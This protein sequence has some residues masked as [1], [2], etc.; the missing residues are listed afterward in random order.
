MT[1]K[2]F[3]KYYAK[4]VARYFKENAS[5]RMFTALAM[6]LVFFLVAWGVYAFAYRGFEFTQ[7]EEFIAE[8]APLY[9]YELFILVTGFLI[10]A[11]AVISSIFTFFRK[12]ESDIW[13]ASTPAHKSLPWVSFTKVVIGASWPFILIALP[14]LLAARAFFEITTIEFLMSFF[15]VLAFSLFCA[16]LGVLVVFAS[17]HASLLLDRNANRF[18]AL[19][20]T[21]LAITLIFGYAAWNALAGTDVAEMFQIDNIELAVVSPERVIDN[22]Q[23]YPSHMPAFTLHYAHRGNVLLAASYFIVTLAML[24]LSVFVFAAAKRKYLKLWQI[25]SEGGFEARKKRSEEKGEGVLYALTSRWSGLSS[26]NTPS[27]ALFKKELLS[28]TRTAK[29]VLWGGFLMLLMFIN[30]FL[31]SVMGDRLGARTAGDLG[32]VAHLIPAL[33]FAVIIFFIGA[34]VLRFVF[35]SFSQEGRAS[36]ILGSSPIDLR[37]LFF[38]KMKLHLSLSALI[39]GLAS[40]LFFSR[41]T[42]ILSD[43]IFTAFPVDFQMLV[44]LPSVLIFSLVVAMIGLSLGVIFVNFK[45]EDP[46]LMSTSLPG[47]LLVLVFLGLGALGAAA[48]YQFILG[49]FV[50]LMILNFVAPMLAVASVAWALKALKKIEFV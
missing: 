23:Y 14:I 44:F 3:I 18:K 45:I 9:I 21:S 48:M 20:W 2:L 26:I 41:S 13:I 27:R 34:F 39:G 10:F 19:V 1:V 15:A 25:F 32:D 4:R 46:Q 47:L 8:A 7:M 36:W 50:Y 5:A 35:P 22:F 40:V 49:T 16:A 38:Q 28:S 37:E 30:I 6:T 29:N 33:Q 11:S 24:V 43:P 42:D 31:V 12:Q 17:A